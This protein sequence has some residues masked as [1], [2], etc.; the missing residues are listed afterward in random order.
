M[1]RWKD[2]TS[3]FPSLEF[4]LECL[5]D[6]GQ[7]ITKTDSTTGQTLKV[8]RYKKLGKLA[9]QVYQA[10][11][12]KFEPEGLT[13][14]ISRGKDSLLKGLI[15][16]RKEFC[17]SITPR[18]FH[19][20]QQE[21]QVL[22]FCPTEPY[23]GLDRVIDQYQD[24]CSNNNASKRRA[25]VRTSNDGLR[26]AC[27]MLDSKY[28][29]SVSGI[30]SKRLDRK[31]SDISGDT[32][33]HFFQHILNESF[34]NPEYRVTAPSEFD[35]FPEDER[36]NWDPNDEAIFQ[37][38]R[39]GEWLR[40]TFDNY[41]RAKYKRALDKWNS[42]TGGGTGRPS[43][44]VNFCGSDRWL[45]YVFCKDMEADFLLAN[46]AG[47]RMPRH[48]QV[49]SGFD[50][51]A[52]SV[53]V[54][55]ISTSDGFGSSNK[56]KK[57]NRVDEEIEECKI[58]RQK[59][60]SHNS[61]TRSMQKE[62]VAMQKE[63]VVLMREMS[64]SVSSYL[65]AKHNREEDQHYIQQKRQ[66]MEQIRNLSVSLREAEKDELGMSPSVKDEYIKSVRSDRA[67]FIKKWRQLNFGGGS[68]HPSEPK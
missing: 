21:G 48:L 26:L 18:S 57:R 6:Q 44:F 47:G 39:T 35:E 5:Q 60:D 43:S 37:K 59:V 36:D 13:K 54:S 28:R 40:E 64:T 1:S 22:A 9:T 51:D 10:I 2:D 32:T 23:A 58:H 16:N 63:T 29:G 4:I 30:L 14:N 20:Y 8:A 24:W 19:P 38:V 3:I 50:N 17:V 46:S 12:K 61:E 25:V 15:G 56:K 41:F 11:I 45:V 67:E 52:T 27:I 34:L 31:K 68:S 7:Q 42:D 53:A 33:T 62:T 66:Y 65:H 49:E 55:E